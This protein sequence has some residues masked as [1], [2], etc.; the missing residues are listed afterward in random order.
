MTPRLRER[1]PSDDFDERTG[2]P[3]YSPLVAPVGQVEIVQFDHRRGGAGESVAVVDNP[4]KIEVDVVGAG[5]GRGRLGVIDVG[6]VGRP[7][8]V[9]S[10]STLLQDERDQCGSEGAREKEN[11]ARLRIRA[12]HGW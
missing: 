7:S 11:N 5:E 8:V 4:A 9:K 12:N 1:K 6:L 2:E 10:G 3:I